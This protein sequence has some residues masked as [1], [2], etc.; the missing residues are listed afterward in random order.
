MT[1]HFFVC[2]PKDPTRK[3]L[4]AWREM[5]KH[6]KIDFRSSDRNEVGLIQTLLID[7]VGK[8]FSLHNLLRSTIQEII[9]TKQINGDDKPLPTICMPKKFLVLRGKMKADEFFRRRY[10]FPRRPGSGKVPGIRT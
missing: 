2:E 3:E 7:K 5:Q 1:F 10:I 8:F 4:G 6:I 9:G